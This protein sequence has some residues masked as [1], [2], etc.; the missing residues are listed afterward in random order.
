MYLRL[1]SNRVWKI[2]HNDGDQKWAWYNIILPFTQFYK[3]ILLEYEVLLEVHNIIHISLDQSPQ[4]QKPVVWR[5]LNL[6][7]NLFSIR[8]S[9][10]TVGPRFA[11][12]NTINFYR[13]HSQT[14][15]STFQTYSLQWRWPESKICHAGSPV[16]QFNSVNFQANV[17]VSY[18][19]IYNEKVFDL[20][21]LGNSTKKSG[22][23]VR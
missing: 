8:D 6:G 5:A 4:S 18:M 14:V 13:N 11:M 16:C 7:P 19:E 21:D 20:L 1:W 3:F 9:F 10:H 15:Q 12:I 17:E 23:K 2:L 22:L